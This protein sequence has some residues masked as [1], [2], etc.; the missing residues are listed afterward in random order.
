[1]N[2]FYSSRD[3]SIRNEQ[4]FFSIFHSSYISIISLEFPAA[5]LQSPNFDKDRP[6]FMNFGAIGSIIGH[7]RNVNQSCNS[8]ENLCF[9]KEITHAFDDQASTKETWSEASK[10][11]FEGRV[12]CIVDQ[13]SSYRVPEVEEFFQDDKIG[14]FYLN[15]NLTQKEGNKFHFKS[16]QI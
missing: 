10:T 11:A 9:L 1:M 2:A 6:P 3:N 4:I 5:I 13:Y 16:Q 8:D 7:V 14:K 15:G 12:R